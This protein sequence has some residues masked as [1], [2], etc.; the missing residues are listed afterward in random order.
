[1][2]NASG[3]KD[4]VMVHSNV[5]WTVTG[6]P[7]WIQMNATT[8]SGDYMLILTIANNQ[9]LQPLT[10][11]ITINGT[12]VPPVV[13]KVTQSGTQPILS[14]DKSSFTVDP[15]GGMDSIIITSNVNWTITIP[16]A[17][18]WLTADK[19]T[20]TSGITKVYFTS[21]KNLLNQSRNA[22]LSIGSPTPG[23]QPTSISFS[24]ENL[25]IT[26]FSPIKGPANTTVTIVGNFGPNPTVTLN[27]LACTVTSSSS[28]QI[29]FT[30]PF[31]GSTGK[32]AVSFSGV[33]LITTGGTSVPL[34]VISTV[35]G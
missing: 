8:G 10:V 34:I 13:I 26:S 28:N 17:S 32:I 33:T 35:S 4:T 11:D 20:G 27:N 1:M 3:G 14:I 24:Q 2:I 30:T 19:L 5:A 12:D 6:I 22:V 16:T 18:P 21:E 29:K 23:I 7:N 25:G 9:G 15:F 31:A